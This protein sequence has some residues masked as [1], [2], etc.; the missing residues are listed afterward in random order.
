MLSKRKMTQ[1]PWNKSTNND[2]HGKNKIFWSISNVLV[3]D[4]PNV[5]LSCS[6]SHGPS[7]NIKG[8]LPFS[9]YSG[10]PVLKKKKKKTQSKKLV[11]SFAQ[12]SY[13]IIF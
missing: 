5:D 4:N 13:N 7:F 9:L 8:L 12:G 10:I 1:A 11:L 3:F 2:S 6:L